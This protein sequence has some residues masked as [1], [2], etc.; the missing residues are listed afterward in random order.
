MSSCFYILMRLLETI[1]YA[2]SQGSFIRCSLDFANDCRRRGKIR[3]ELLGSSVDCNCPLA[4]YHYADVWHLGRHS[5]KETPIRPSA[6]RTHL[7]DP[8]AA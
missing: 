1:K 2:C 6:G 3:Q 5:G 7:W 8:D 4:A